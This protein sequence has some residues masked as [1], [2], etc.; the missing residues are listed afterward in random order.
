M[1][2]LSWTPSRALGLPLAA[3][4][5]AVPAFY[6]VRSPGGV[7]LQKPA[8]GAASMRAAPAALQTRVAKRP[9]GPQPV[10]RTE[11]PLTGSQRVA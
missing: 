2:V 9:T 4:A 3:L 7:V 10:M 5:A 8:P 1:S 6:A 11:E